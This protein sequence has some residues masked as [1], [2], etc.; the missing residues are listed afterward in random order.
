M[1][2]IVRFIGELFKI[3]DEKIHRIEALVTALPYG[4]YTGWPVKK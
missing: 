1:L 3:V 2:A 4:L